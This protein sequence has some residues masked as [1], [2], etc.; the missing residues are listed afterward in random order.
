VKTYFVAILASVGC[1]TIHAPSSRAVVVE[2][3]PPGAQILVDGEP[4]AIAPA[5]VRVTRKNREISLRMPGYLD[6]ICPVETTFGWMYLAGDLATLGVGAFVDALTNRWTLVDT[7][8]CVVT[9]MPGR[10]SPRAELVGA[11][12]RIKEKI[13]FEL[14][15]AT[16]RPESFGLLDEV[17]RVISSHPQLR[18]EVQG[19]TDASGDAEHNRELSQQRATAVVR[20]LGGRGIAMAQLHAKGFGASTPIADNSTDVGRERNRR[21]E[22]RVVQ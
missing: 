22:F 16:I 19:H 14:D 9:M 17:A 11:Q 10:E 3:N 20:Y 21:V 8:S 7:K 2:S 15:K 5:S 12:I 6:K 4:T 13:Q 1:A 18:V